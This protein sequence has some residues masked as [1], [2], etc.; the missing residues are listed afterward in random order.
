V[1]KDVEVRWS[2]RDAICLWTSETVQRLVIEP[3]LL[4]F[5]KAIW[6]NIRSGQDA[7]RT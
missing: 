6:R 5:E 7:G 1:L 4:G 2:V 3:F